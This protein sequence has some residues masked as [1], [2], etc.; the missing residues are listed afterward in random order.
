MRRGLVQV[1]PY[2]KGLREPRGLLLTAKITK[3]AL[4]LALGLGL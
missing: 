1:G 2:A 3:S 4:G